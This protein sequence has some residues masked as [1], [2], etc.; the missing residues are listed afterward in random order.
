MRAASPPAAP[1]DEAARAASRDESNHLS[2]SRSPGP[3]TVQT[4]FLEPSLS[5]E[6]PAAGISTARATAFGGVR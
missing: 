4:F 2:D 6:R 5:A 1:R 3:Q